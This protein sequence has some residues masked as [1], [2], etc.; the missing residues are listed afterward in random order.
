MIPPIPSL[1]DYQVSP[2]NGFLPAEAPLSRLPDPYYESWEEIAGDLHNLITS[3]KIR[4]VVEDLPQLSTSRLRTEAEWRRAYLVLGFLVNSYVWGMEPAQERVP[5]CLSIPFLKVSDHL[6]I[7]PV[8]TYAACCLWNYK[9]IYPAGPI[10]LVENLMTHVTFTGLMDESWFYLISV[11]I[12]AR[13]APT[14]PLM[15]EAMKAAR[16]GDS[17][18]VSECLTMFAERIMDLRELLGR[19]T[20]QCTPHAFYF[21]IR[22]LLAGSKNM[23]E[24]G[25]P[26]GVLFETGTGNEEYRQYAGG[27]NAQ[28]SLIQFFDIALGVQH[29]PTGVKKDEPPIKVDQGHAPPPP[30]HNFIE[31]MRSYMPGPHRRFLEHLASVANIRDYVEANPEDPTLTTAYDECLRALSSFRDKHLQIVS[32]YI[33]IMSQ[34]SKRRMSTVAAAT[35]PANPV[36][37]IPGNPLGLAK[38]EAAKK[39]LKGTGGTK[40]M[41]FLKQSRDETMEPATGAWSKTSSKFESYQARSRNITPLSTPGSTPRSSSPINGFAVRSCKVNDFED[42]PTAS[43][44][45]V[46][47]A[48]DWENDDVGGLCHY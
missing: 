23:A 36:H 6:D 33:V 15:L 48:G 20:E 30:R 21:R 25:L 1:E 24:A 44:I 39:G 2:E 3:K 27:S 19:M 11:A 4:R 14:I 35:S 42:M 5:K 41:P 29:R 13:G 43:R 28:S 16:Q 34:E 47:M 22:P 46:G 26:N 18:T 12:E 17:L 32:R 10:D 45:G 40:L 37:D 38:G 8:V 9:P 7:P 31:E